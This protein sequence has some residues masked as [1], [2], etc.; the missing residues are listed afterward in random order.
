[1]RTGG[2]SMARLGR[3]R[4]I[5]TG[6]VERG[7]VPGIITGV[8]RHGEVHVDA[9]GNKSL[10]GPEQVARDTIFRLASMSKPITAAATMILAEECKLRLDDAVEKWLPE[11]ANRKV[12]K[13]IGE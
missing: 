13:R 5:M 9:V 4:T 12:L 1:M 10:D 11:L 7:E 3:L 6:Y 2:L 8:S